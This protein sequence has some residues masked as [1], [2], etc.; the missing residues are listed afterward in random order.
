M[1]QGTAEGARVQERASE[2]VAP[3]PARRRRGCVPNAWG[4]PLALPTRAM[5]RRMCSDCL[6][7]E[8]NRANGWD[9]EVPDCPLY[10]AMPWRGRQMPERLK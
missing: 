4:V 5:I 3:R 2:R 7:L 6:C 9:C 8:A 1:T 10:P